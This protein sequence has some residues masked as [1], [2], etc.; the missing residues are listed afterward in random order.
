MVMMVDATTIVTTVW[1]TVLI[2]GIIKVNNI[3]ILD[4]DNKCD[5]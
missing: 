3:T 4:V 5:D 2:D 1:A